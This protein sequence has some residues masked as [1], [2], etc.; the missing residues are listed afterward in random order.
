MKIAYE[1]KIV[2]FIDVLGFASLVF[3]KSIEPI[4]SYFGYVLEEFS[5]DLKQYDF[6]FA[7]IS[8]SIVVHLPI[9]RENFEAL[10]RTLVKLQTKLI[11]RGIIVRGGISSGELFTDNANNVIVGSA[12]IKAYKLEAEAHFPRIIIDRALIPLF[13]DGSIAMI[14]ANKGRIMMIPP[15]RYQADFPYLNYTRKLAIVMQ[16]PKLNQVKQLFLENHYLN[17]HI[18]KYMWLMEHVLQSVHEQ[19]IYLE[20]KETQNKRDSYRMRLLEDFKASLEKL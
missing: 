4:Q 7:L 18:D 19:M 12:L 5:E 3:A 14:E 10:T 1:N 11:T 6:Q 13:Y 17:K 15:G 20:N 16:I 2:A 8:D 9:G